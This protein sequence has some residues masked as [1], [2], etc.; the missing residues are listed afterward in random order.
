[1]AKIKNFVMYVRYIFSIIKMLLKHLLARVKAPCFGHQVEVKV[2][3][4]SHEEV[5]KQSRCCSSPTE[6][7]L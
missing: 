1:M 4:F 5:P 6:V 2:E 7:Y 3:R